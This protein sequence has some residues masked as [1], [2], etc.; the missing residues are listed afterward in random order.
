MFRRLAAAVTALIL[1][2][3]VAAPALAGGWAEIVADARTEEPPPVE[4]HPIEV[5]FT[6]LQHGE[7]PAGWESPTVTFTEIATGKTFQVAATGSGRDGHF[8]ASA[9]MPTA[10]FWT[11][12]V[13]LRDLATDPVSH[14]LAVHTSAGAAPTLD[15][16]MALAAIDRARR[17]VTTE[18]TGTLY[19]EIER[20]NGQ[21]DGQ[22]AITTGLA[23]D[24]DRIAAERDAL[25]TRLDAAEEALAAGGTGVTLIGIV[26]LAILGGAAAGFAMAWLAGRSRPRDLEVSVSSGSPSAPAVSPR[27]SLPG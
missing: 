7:T 16:A 23:A 19:T 15:P 21:L 5:G 12:S 20:V 3:L 10:G 25:A 8:I 13:T 17:D 1:V 9:T 4:G 6:V 26:T 14:S 22:R 11:W 24:V 18:L 2:L 27:G